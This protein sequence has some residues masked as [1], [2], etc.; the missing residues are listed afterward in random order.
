MTNNDKFDERYAGEKNRF[1]LS[2]EAGGSFSYLEA[3]AN[4]VRRRF[5][6][7]RC[8]FRSSRTCA[9]RRNSR[10]K[11]LQMSHPSKVCSYDVIWVPE[12]CR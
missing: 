5:V 11:L 6:I 7:G 1:A 3:C 10:V 12:A 2:T 9:T 4:P 8:G